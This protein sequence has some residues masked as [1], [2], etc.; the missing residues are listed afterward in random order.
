MV[1]PANPRRARVIAWGLFGSALWFVVLGVFAGLLFAHLASNQARADAV[2]VKAAQRTRAVIVRVTEFSA[3]GLPLYVDIRYRLSTGN[4][5]GNL[6]LS[7]ATRNY[8]VGDHLVVLVD[9]R[10]PTRPRLPQAVRGGDASGLNSGRTSGLVVAGVGLMGLFGTSL[11]L[12]SDSRNRG[13][14]EQV[15]ARSAPQDGFP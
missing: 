9:V 8:R 1:S 4:F 12:V 14:A 11:W 10:F 15:V 6:D 7:L 3:D 5:L 13:R 2:F